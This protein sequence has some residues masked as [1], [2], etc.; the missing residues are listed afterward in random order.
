MTP[1]IEPSS[2][3]EE[4]QLLACNSKL[5]DLIPS[6]VFEL[7]KSMW[8]VKSWWVTLHRTNAREPD[9]NNITSEM[10]WLEIK[11]W[12][13]PRWVIQ[14]ESAKLDLEFSFV[15]TIKLSKSRSQ[16]RN[17]YRTYF[18]IDD[19]NQEWLFV[20]CFWT[21][22]KIWIGKPSTDLQSI[23]AVLQGLFS[24]LDV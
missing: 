9:I 23:R 8:V 2:F 12:L 10:S 14:Q 16:F 5:I 18:Q 24:L 19:N 13:T 21:C 17:D 22:W 20:L 1:Y 7:S 6:F 11:S 3:Q 4:W 15:L